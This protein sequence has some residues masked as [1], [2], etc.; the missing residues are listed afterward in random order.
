MSEKGGEWT[1]EPNPF[2]A[3]SP[4]DCERGVPSLASGGC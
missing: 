4:F 3:Q 1:A 2:F